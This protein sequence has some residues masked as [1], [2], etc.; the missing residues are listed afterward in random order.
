M[1]IIS[2]QKPFFHVIIEETFDKQEYYEVWNELLFLQ[3]KMKN[4]HET[5]AAHNVYGAASKNGFGIFLND[6]FVS[7]NYSQI[8]RSTRKF[9]NNSSIADAIE[10]DK[11]DTYF[12]L[13][14]R[15]IRDS[16]LVQCYKN[17]DYYFPHND[18]SLFTIVSM[19]YNLPK[20]YSGGELY[21]PEYDHKISLENNCSLIFP[22]VLLH[23]VKEVKL[24]SSDP[25]DFRYTISL[26]LED[27]LPLE[28]NNE[29]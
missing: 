18:Q 14:N 27:R 8:F 7:G 2:I 16:V 15:V 9:F 21:F 22:S 25:K 13:F 6:I 19:M 11:S 24:D 20:K 29:K 28:N 1:K 12:K 5:G 4:G 23:E 26:F 3:P 17:G 10:S